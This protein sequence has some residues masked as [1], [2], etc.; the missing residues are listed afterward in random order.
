MPSP[1]W[2]KITAF[3]LILVTTPVAV[4][5]GIASL[6][7]KSTPAAYASAAPP[8]AV[9]ETRTETKRKLMG[10]L[11]EH[12]EVT[13]EHRSVGLDDVHTGSLLLATDDRARFVT[14][15]RLDTDVTVDVTGLLARV[16]VTQSFANPSDDWVEGVYAFPLPEDAAVDALRMKV[17]ER[18]IEGRIMEKQAA[19]ATY[20]RAR[21]DGSRASLV[22]QDRPNL[23]RTAVA[24]IAPR[25]TVEVEI[26]YL[27]T[28]RYDVGEI[29]LRFPL[30][31]T[32]RYSPDQLSAGMLPS[33]QPVSPVPPGLDAS[34]AKIEV[35]LNPGFPLREVASGS[36]DIRAERSG[37]RQRI[38]LADAAVPMDRDFL[39]SWTPAIGAEPGAAVFSENR[40]GQDYALVMFMPPQQSAA[41]KRLP[42]ETIIVIDTSGSMAG[43]SFEQA[44]EAVTLA[45]DL[46]DEGDYFNL[47]EFN[48]DFSALFQQAR[49]ATRTNLASARRYLSQLEAN[50]GTNMAPALA[51]ALDANAGTGYLRQVVFMTDGAV[52]NERELFGLIERQLGESRLFTVG[53]GSAPNSFFMRNAA[54]SGRGT[55]SYIASTG[56]V[57]EKMAALFRKIESPVLKDVTVEW[58]GQSADVWPRRTPDL[59]QSEPLMLAARLDELP[60]SVTIRGQQAGQPWQ[61]EVPLTHAQDFRGVS[62]LWARSKVASL[63]DGLSRGELPGVVRGRVLPLALEHHLVTRFTSLVAVDDQPVRPLQASLRPEPARMPPTA[64][65]QMRYP[66]TGVAW[67]LQVILGLMS[68]CLAGALVAL[69]PVR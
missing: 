67:P 63:M 15:T 69:R 16:V 66:V 46:L 34:L 10:G 59:Y 39:L 1:S 55:Y 47:I 40:N 35:S 57:R 36:H 2:P 61:R 21:R 48:S 64:T 52:D 38:S 22:E 27:E 4:L 33:A 24:N 65:V 26:S 43:A 17:G 51:R 60:A 9:V 37:A 68:L 3:K 44:R 20:E 30:A 31:I 53:I 32:P 8:P 50:G 58:P 14:A 54:D 6:A 28:L 56:E 42:R 12:S 45:L 49:P 19:R 7:P 41:I 29:S 18:V 25:D 5:A 23:F 62:T 13:F 11:W